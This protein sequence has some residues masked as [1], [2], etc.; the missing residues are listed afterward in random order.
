[1]FPGVRALLKQLKQSGIR[2]L[3][4]TARKN[5]FVLFQQLSRLQLTNLFETIS[6]VSPRFAIDQKSAFLDLW[7]PD[8]FIGDT[9]SDGEAAKRAGVSFFSV[10]C[11]Q[12]DPEYLKQQGYSPF[13]DLCSAFDSIF[14]THTYER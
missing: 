9:E 11:G 2:L 6:V 8:L 13:T 1:L 10:G 5:S 7:S 3:L 12:R 4:L 14:K